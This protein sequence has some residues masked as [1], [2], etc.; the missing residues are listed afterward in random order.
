M[1]RCNLDLWPVDLESRSVVHQASR[2]QSLRNFSEIEKSPAE[3]WIILPIFAHV[4]SR[5]ELDL[6]TL[7]FYSTSGIILINFVQNFSEIE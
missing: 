5:R 2:G 1:S 4:I 3:L 6:L 7:N